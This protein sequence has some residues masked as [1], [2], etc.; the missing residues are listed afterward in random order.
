MSD[1]GK[2]KTGQ[3][4]IHDKVKPSY[5]AYNARVTSI[6][7]ETNSGKIFAKIDGL[8][9]KISIT[10]IAIQA[11][12]L[13]CGLIH[14]LPKVNE[15]VIVFIMDRELPHA[16]RFWIGP[17]ISQP[18]FLNYDGER[19]AIKNAL[20]DV[21]WSTIADANG[22][23]AKDD[24]V[25]YQG[26][27][28]ADLLFR[29]N[30]ATLRAGKF[31]EN[32]QLKFNDK[33]QAYIKVQANTTI[34]KTTGA[35]TKGSDGTTKGSVAISVANK[36]LLISHGGKLNK[37]KN[38]KVLTPNEEIS[39]TDLLNIIEGAYSAVYGEK[40]VEL[41]QLLKNFVL[42]HTHAYPGLP[43]LTNEKSAKAILDFDLNWL[44]ATN[45]KLV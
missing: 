7:D 40:L 22:A 31:V 15:T 5:N 35:T 10:D 19:V 41:M 1:I 2:F 16:Q 27:D 23:Y 28:N 25:A 21:G 33:N 44:L 9:D 8:D 26:R 24:E 11:S 14:A 45:I 20:T 17:V 34:E 36:L 3:P 30:Q 39:E 42:N 12:P 32:Q 43:P 4:N 13:E 29:K 18:Q 37:I 6:K 38:L